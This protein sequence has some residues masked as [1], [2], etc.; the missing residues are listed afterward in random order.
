M[1]NPRYLVLVLLVPFTALAQVGSWQ[2]YTSMKDIRAVAVADNG[3][4]AATSGGVFFESFADGSYQRY[5]NTNG[6]ATIDVTA[7]FVDA[8][9]NVIVGASSGALNIRKPG[10]DWITV[11]DIQRSADKPRRGINRFREI[12]GALYIATDF[13]IVVYDVEKN[14][15]GDTYTRLGEL[16]FQTPVNDIFFRNG[17]IWAATDAGIAYASLSHPNLQDP[18]AWNV[19][20]RDDGIQSEKIICI[21]EVGGEII[22]GT[23]QGLALYDG[24]QWLAETPLG[25]YESAIYS[26]VST[27]DAL[28]LV[29]QWE[30]IKVNPGR[31]TQGLG[32]NLFDAFYPSQT[33]FSDLA[34]DGSE[35]YLASNLGISSYPGGMQNERW[36][37]T[38]PNGPN[39]SQFLSMSVDGNGLLWSASGRDGKGF[40]AYSFDGRTWENYTAS[41]NDIISFND[42]VSTAPGPDGSAWFGTWG[43]GVY[44]RNADGS[45][46]HFWPRTVPGYPGIPNDTFAITGGIVTDMDD[47]V[48]ICH[49]G[50][51]QRMI[52]RYSPDGTWRWYN[53]PSVTGNPDLGGIAIDEFDNKWIVVKNGFKRGLLIFNENRTLDDRSDDSWTAVPAG[54]ERPILA[55]NVTSVAV[56]KFG[57]VWVGTN[58]GIRTIFDP[59]EPER[60]TRTC[61]NT[62]CN[63]EGQQINCIAI[64]PVNNKWLGTPNGVIVLSEDG[65]SII[66]QY[67]TENSPLVD[68]E[69]T[70]ITI[71]PETGVAYIGTNRGLSALSTPYQQ[72]QATFDELFVYPNPFK[73]KED[74]RLS[75]QGLVE[76]SSIKIM[77]V[78][79]NLVAEIPTPGGNIGFWDGR[80]SAG[81]WAPSGVYYIVGYNLDGSEVALTKVAVINQ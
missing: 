1:L 24:S 50:N 9:G 70:S 21:G 6:L 40:G 54:S 60:V 59:T 53:D 51:G 61:F 79:G 34:L 64:D 49:A 36:V 71:H 57:D 28:Y 74:E 55:D 31:G 63:I 38:S 68:N 35:L 41:S 48:Y 23:D 69:V 19:F 11:P 30:L 56:D 25:K 4:W 58:V 3:I 5:T 62:R 43:K 22:V 14:E 39:S 27:Q 65:S 80:T 29:G 46:D 44:R 32:D 42:F 72:P 47:N 45:V 75:I 37:F 81:D 78:S 26:M 18:N 33:F 12:N 76:E 10:A 7:I 52:G 2:T 73:P 17:E 8:A 16:T 20:T 66:G 13:G 67:T 15:F 77:S